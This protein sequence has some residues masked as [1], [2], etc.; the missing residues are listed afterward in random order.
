MPHKSPDHLSVSSEHTHTLTG[1]LAKD[2]GKFSAKNPA[3]G[4]GSCGSG[5]TLEIGTICN[6]LLSG[7]TQLQRGVVVEAA[8]SAL[9][10]EFVNFLWVVSGTTAI[11]HF[12]LDARRFVQFRAIVQAFVRSTPR[13]AVRFLCASS[14]LADA[15][16]RQMF[17]LGAATMGLT[18]QVNGNET[19]SVLNVSY[20]GLRIEGGT[21]F[22]TGQVVT[23]TLHFQ[24]TVFAGSARVCNV[25]PG[26]GGTFRCG[27]ETTADAR[28][29]QQGLQKI[30]VSIQQA[31]LRRPHARRE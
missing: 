9:V 25:Q 18:A 1:T 30:L 26:E 28:Q 19:W 13:P 5:A 20:N 10:L 22:T 11:I 15:N 8:D 4:D 23:V 17:R 3:Q 6:V 16:R 31:Q 12:H 2:V 14:D 29:L 21:P 24:S 7:E 27:L